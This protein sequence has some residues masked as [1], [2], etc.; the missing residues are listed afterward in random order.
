[1]RF[2]DFNRTPAI[3][4]GCKTAFDPEQIIRS[5]KGKDTSRPAAK[6]EPVATS[7]DEAANTDDEAL[8]TGGDAGVAEGMEFEEESGM[9]SGESSESSDSDILRQDVGDEDGDD[10]DGGIPTISTEES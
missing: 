2:Y 4:P 1:M 7:G 3:C 6:S 8:A 5:Q 10:G 9:E